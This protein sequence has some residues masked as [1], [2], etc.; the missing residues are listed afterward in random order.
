MAGRL[1]CFKHT[2]TPISLYTLRRVHLWCRRGDW[3]VRRIK[4]WWVGF[5]YLTVSS[6]GAGLPHDG[7]NTIAEPPE[8]HQNRFG[9]VGVV[10]I[11]TMGVQWD[12]GAGRVR[13]CPRSRRGQGSRV[14]AALR[15]GRSKHNTGRGT[16][17][18]FP[19]VH[20]SW[21]GSGW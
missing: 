9:I 7:F 6:E 8:C 19:I 14:L 12:V 15:R 1:S 18:N 4:W 21:Y 13:Q 10:P 5:V 11:P 16:P 17:V 3:A 2:S 20:P